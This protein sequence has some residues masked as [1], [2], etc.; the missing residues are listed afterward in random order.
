MASSTG[1][2]I[3]PFAQLKAQEEASWQMM[4]RMRRA[5]LDAGAKEV[6]V[7]IFECS[8][9]DYVLIEKRIIAAMKES[10]S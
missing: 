6:G 2:R 8:D 10:S 5:A 1:R 7:D 9:A 4:Q 3:I